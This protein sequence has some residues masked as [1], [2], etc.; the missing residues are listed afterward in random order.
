VAGVF[1]VKNVMTED[2]Q[3]AGRD[4]SIQEVLDTMLKFDISSVVVVQHG[5]P[6][7]IVTHKDILLKVLKPSLLPSALTARQVMS[8]PVTTIEEEASVEEA[9]SLMASKRIKKLPVVID[10][11]LTGIV[12]SMDLV[13]EQPKLVKLLE[14]LAR[15]R[16]SRR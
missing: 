6:V 12:T 10:G 3:S 7:G 11:K 13:R 15:P 5:R 8:V 1:V 16:S 14:D 2:V 4:T 9:A